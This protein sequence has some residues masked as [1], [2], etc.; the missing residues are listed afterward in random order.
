MASQNSDEP[1][2]ASSGT[3]SAGGSG[4]ISSSQSE[5]A[6]PLWNY[7]TKL[8]KK[9]YWR[10]SEFLISIFLKAVN[11]FGEAKD[12]FFIANL[13]KNVIDEV[14][15]QNAPKNIKG[16]E[17][18][19]GLCN[20]IIEIHGD[21]EKIKNFIMNHNMR[22]AK[23]E[24]DRRRRRERNADSWFA[25]DKS[26]SPNEE[27]ANN[28]PITEGSSGSRSGIPYAKRISEVFSKLLYCISILPSECLSYEL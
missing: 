9:G 25:F 14:G 7:V 24:R 5:N 21:A 16:N 3:G 22:S 26:S 19:Y 12:K 23:I 11:C 6:S 10:N 20:W 18:T 1:N 8:K 28:E 4:S 15:H 27:A 17:E 2:F 13:M